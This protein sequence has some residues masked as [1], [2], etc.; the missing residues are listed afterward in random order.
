MDWKFSSNAPIYTQLVEQIKL[1]II[2]GAYIPGQRIPAVR[3]LAQEAGVNPNTMQRAMQELER[4]GLLFSIRTSGRFVTEDI[5][6]IQR[7]KEAMA[8]KLMEEFLKQMAALGCE[9]EEIIR[10]M[11]D[12]LEGGE[13]HGDS[14]V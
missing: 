6:M 2:S 1:R 12:Y 4:L 10:L 13:V 14:G 7:T 8:K 11:T 5:A 9:K 3:E